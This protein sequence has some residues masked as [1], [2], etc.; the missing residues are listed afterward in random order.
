MRKP[1]NKEDFK[2]RVR[3]W[4]LILDVSVRVISI[5]TMKNKWASYTKASGLLIFNAELIEMDRDLGDYVIVHEL[6]HF[7]T[8][9]HGKLWKSLM[10]AHLGDYETLEQQ[11]KS[12]NIK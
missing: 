10:R 4:A 5:R 1:Q 6:L 9:N 3:E 2:N 8:P 12:R 7:R 11:L